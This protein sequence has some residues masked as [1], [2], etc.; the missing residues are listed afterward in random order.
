MKIFFKYL[1]SQ[2]IKINENENENEKNWLFN[3]FIFI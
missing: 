3:Y 2:I 1:N